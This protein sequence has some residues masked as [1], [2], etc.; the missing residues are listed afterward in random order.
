MALCSTKQF[1]SNQWHFSA[2][3]KHNQ[4]P[5]TQTTQQ[6]HMTVQAALSS[7]NQWHFPVPTNTTATKG[8]VQH[9]TMAL[10]STKQFNSNEWHSHRPFKQHPQ[11][12]PAPTSSQALN[13]KSPLKSLISR[14]HEAD[15]AIISHL[16]SLSRICLRFGPE[17]I[18][19]Q[20][21]IIWR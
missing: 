17:G 9:Q 19:S 1:N 12:F 11:C 14:T 5:P 15:Q 7:T 6:G 4:H 8:N 20:G 10:C 21:L 2:P 13:Q 18:S 3:T 16:A